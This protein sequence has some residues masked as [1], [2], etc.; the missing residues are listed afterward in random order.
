MKKL[1]LPFTAVAILA[2]CGGSYNHYEKNETYTQDGYDCIVEINE[3]GAINHAN[4]DKSDSTVYPN[5][6]CGELLNKKSEAAAP[7]APAVPVVAKV[8]LAEP[9]PTTTTIRS[10]KRVYLR[11]NCKASYGTWCE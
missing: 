7:E 3:E 9:Q 4:T 11:N 6:S 8:V 10:V 2:G 5:T 1:I